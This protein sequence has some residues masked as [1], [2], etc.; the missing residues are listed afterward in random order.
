MST[1]R[2]AWTIDNYYGLPTRPKEQTRWDTIKAGAKVSGMGFAMGMI[3]GSAIVGI[4]S[5]INGVRPNGKQCMSTG[6]LFGLM[7][8][9]GAHLR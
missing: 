3:M 1:P 7:F 5:V 6:G 4:N 8:A 9:V 2:N